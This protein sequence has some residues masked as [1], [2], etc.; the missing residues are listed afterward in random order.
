MNEKKI[1]ADLVWADGDG[2]EFRVRVP[3][4]AP[5]TRSAALVATP[6]DVVYLTAAQC[7][8]V[9]AHLTE[10]ADYHE[11]AARQSA[12]ALPTNKGAVIVPADGREYIETSLGLC[13]YVMIHAGDGRWRGGAG[14]IASEDITPGT[15]KVAGE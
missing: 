2:D 9:A 8:A 12:P 1:P 11:E 15:W 6:G 5:T 10:L 3:H 7:R 14:V 4:E 13:H